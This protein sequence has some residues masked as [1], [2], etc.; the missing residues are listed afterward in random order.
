MATS[1]VEIAPELQQK[2]DEQQYAERHS[3]GMFPEKLV[4]QSR[5][6]MKSLL[7]LVALLTRQA[8][9]VIGIG[10]AACVRQ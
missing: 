8:N 2:P 3:P 5:A 6:E 10:K 1:P 9:V 4:E 7:T